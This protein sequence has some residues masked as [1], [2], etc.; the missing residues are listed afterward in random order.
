MVAAVDSKDAA[1]LEFKARFGFE[2][3]GTDLDQYLVRP[4]V[5]A[6]IIATSNGAHAPLALRALHAGKHVMVQKPMGTSS[7]EAEAMVRAAEESSVKLM[8]SFFE[9]FLP[10]VV[11]AKELVDAGLIG[12]PHFFKAMMGWYVPEG[13]AEGWRSDPKI[14]G[15]GVIMD[16]SVHHVANALYLLGDPEIDSVYAELEPSRPGAPEDT[17]VIVMR[18]KGAI[19]E[20][21]GS[22]RALQPGGS[23]EMFRDD[24]QLF[25]T[26][27]TVQWD[28]SERPTLRMHS[29]KSGL[30]SPLVGGGWM[31]PRPPLIPEAER[32]YS[33]HLNG[34]EN[35]WVA[36]HRH[37]VGSCLSGGL[38]RG[39][40]R[41]GLKTQRVIEA[42]YEA[43][44]EGRRVSF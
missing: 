38:L 5:G 19:C 24:W 3:C 4:D 36:E 11:R 13:A 22:R 15:G 7:A 35:P 34:E 30:T 41:F 18:T 6:V 26:E 25:G 14:S 21:S 1:A 12:Q 31:A 32:A 29:E 33:L 8:V 17:A 23:A 10:P 40:G 16:G 42:A 37:F 44:R 39:D 9:L 27:G 43:G 2:E 28:S 20:I